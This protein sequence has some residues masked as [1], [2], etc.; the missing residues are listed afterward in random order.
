[1]FGSEDGG[2]AARHKA[3]KH[4]RKSQECASTSEQ[5]TANEDPALHLAGA[6]KELMH[7]V[8]VCDV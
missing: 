2:W 3:H 6:E 4:T 1:V 7:A 8:L 5:P